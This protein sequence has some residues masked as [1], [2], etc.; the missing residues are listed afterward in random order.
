ML[1]FCTH[2]FNLLEAVW[3]WNEQQQRFDRIVLEKYTNGEIQDFLKVTVDYNQ[4]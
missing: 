3:A 1:V 4:R 2:L